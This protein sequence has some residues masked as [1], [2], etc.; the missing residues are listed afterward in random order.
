MN[1]PQRHLISPADAG[2][3]TEYPF[4][5]KPSN[6]KTVSTYADE[7][8][9]QLDPRFN[10]RSESIQHEFH[11]PETSYVDS[12]IPP[13]AILVSEWIRH[14][15][16]SPVDKFIN[17]FSTMNNIPF[18]V[19]LSV[20][21]AKGFLYTHF[22]F[23]GIACMLVNAAQ[24]SHRFYAQ[25]S[26]YWASGVRDSLYAYEYIPAGADVMMMFPDFEAVEEESHVLSRASGRKTPYFVEASSRNIT[27][28]ADQIESYLATG[29]AET[30]GVTR[31]IPR[32]SSFQFVFNYLVIGKAT[33]PAVDGNAYFRL[34]RA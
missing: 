8:S 20:D 30:K 16:L 14:S 28:V 5:P 10:S 25:K 32:G 21:E 24:E 26:T 34:S 18:P 11:Y 7:L 9:Y 2:A 3:L 27:T 23:L 29:Q 13:D 33:T 1:F 17:A 12:S 19:G 4:V 22:R 15:A 31:Y 6:D